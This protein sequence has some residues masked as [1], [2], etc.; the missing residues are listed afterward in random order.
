MKKKETDF[1]YNYALLI[2][3]NELD[4][5]INQKTFE[6]NKFSRKI[7]VSSG[8]K[9]ALEFL[10]NIEICKSKDFDL[11]PEIIFVDINMPM[12]DGLQFVEKFKE[13]YP[14]KFDSI[15]LVILTSSLDNC[16]KERALAISKRIVF[17]NKP[18]TKD[19]LATL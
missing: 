16:D 19:A 8:S 15:K 7:F 9:N 18:L 3:D 2:D 5:F 1:K 11:F 17:L 12:M 4:N 6:K 13:I 14:N 10:N